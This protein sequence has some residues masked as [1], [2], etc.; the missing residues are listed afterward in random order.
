MSARIVIASLWRITSGGCHRDIVKAATERRTH[1]AA[2]TVG[3]RPTGYWG[4]KSA[5][6][7]TKRK[8]SKRMQHRWG[9]VTIWSMR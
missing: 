8:S 2:N 6:A 9:C 5:P 7:R 3:E 4:Y 1:A